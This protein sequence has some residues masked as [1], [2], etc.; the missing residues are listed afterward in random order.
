M[1]RVE[2]IS[3]LDGLE[4]VRSDWERL[5]TKLPERT[6]FTSWDWSYYWSIAF[7]DVARPVLLVAKDGEETVG[8]APL[9]DYG[10][11][12]LFMLGAPKVLAEYVSFLYEPEIADDVLH[13]FFDYLR[14]GDGL[15]WRFLQVVHADAGGRF[16][17]AAA[18]H[19]DLAP[20]VQ[21]GGRCWLTELPASGEP[22]LSTLKK[23]L[24]RSVR[25]VLK[26][27][28]DVTVR[29][30]TDGLDLDVA[31]QALVTTHQAR[32]NAVGEP[33][34]FASRRFHDFHKLL[35]S[36]WCPE[37]RAVLIVL[38]DGNRPVAAEYVFVD[39]DTAYGYAA[40]ML[41]EYR[42]RAV[43][44]LALYHTW[45]YCVQRGLKYLDHLSGDEEYKRRWAH[46]QR[47]L[48]NIRLRGPGLRAAC[49]HALVAGW[50]ATRTTLRDLC[51]RPLRSAIRYVR[52]HAAR[53]LSGK[54]RQPQHLAAPQASTA[55]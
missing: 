2:L 30:T 14:R 55:K 29:T 37:G 17:A 31:W 39:L 35:A 9:A 1:I 43:G 44:V 7:G 46:R 32:W 38:S 15:R 12:R 19:T 16:A 6:P 20:F 8:I 36:H 49:E 28:P 27:N 26:L 23:S 25:R 10:S 52:K 34:V 24:R 48:V 42:R 13:A 21:P 3:G 45:V 50:R 51:P 54:A 33:G 22:Q 40:G 11:G 41:P 47:P 4:A 5:W 53:A 18:E